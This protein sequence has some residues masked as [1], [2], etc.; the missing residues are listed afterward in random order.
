MTSKQWQSGDFIAAD[1]KD[2][3][4]MVAR[5]A[6]A[7]QDERS[8]K[9][10]VTNFPLLIRIRA[11]IKTA[12]LYCG[13]GPKSQNAVMHK[14]IMSIAN[15]LYLKCVECIRRYYK[16]TSLQELDILHEQLRMLWLIYFELGYLSFRRGKSTGDEAL[17]IRRFEHINRQLDEIGAMLGGWIRSLRGRAPG[18]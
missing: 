13:H 14:D 2:V 1:P 8:Q 5:Q 18:M 17:G 10:R 12:H 9:Y 16:K 15:R 3:P 7:E 6:Q 4:A 11:H